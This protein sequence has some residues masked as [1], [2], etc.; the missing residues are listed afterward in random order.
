MKL[1]H[2]LK[3]APDQSAEILMKALSE[4][5]E[6]TVFPL[7]TELVDYEELIDLIFEHQKVIS[8]W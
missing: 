5:E 4:G 1:L 2:I 7:Y 6:T 8:W 3:S